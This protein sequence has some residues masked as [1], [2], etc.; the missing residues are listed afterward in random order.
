M[1]E[2][3]LP[4]SIFVLIIGTNGAGKSTLM[5]EIIRRVGGGKTVGSHTEVADPQ[6]AIVGVYR[7]TAQ[8]NC[9]GDRIKDLDVLY[10]EIRDLKRKFRVVLCEGV[11]LAT[12]SNDKVESYTGGSQHTLII[13][14][15]V[16]EATARSRIIGRGGYFN[17]QTYRR[18]TATVES[19][20]RKYK[21]IGC[22][23]MRIGQNFTPE[24]KAD[25]VLR[26]IS[27]ITNQPIFQ[28]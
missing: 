13:G 8:T 14:L 19:T 25:F 17:E 1:N 23:I 6:M 27:Q 9:G 4:N 5:R 11:R 20:L 15:P 3:I 28:S 26:A 12:F 18:K 10:R 16:D 24:E 7:G 22:K 2:S 21:S